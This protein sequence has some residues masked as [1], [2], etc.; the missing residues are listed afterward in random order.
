MPAAS[1]TA[2]SAAPIFRLLARIRRRAWASIWIDSLAVVILAAVAT[3]GLLLALDWLLEPPA[4]ARAIALA[5]VAGLLLWLVIVR[6]F[7][8]LATPLP[9]ASLALAVE[10]RHPDFGDTL[11]TAVELATG[12]T[13]TVD[14]DLAARTT[15]AAA[16]LARVTRP[17]DLFRGRRLAG[18]A[19]AGLAAVGGGVGMAARWPDLARI[20]VRRMVLLHDVAWP[21][22]V[23][24]EAEGFRDGVRKVPRGADV[25]VVVRARSTA[26]LPESVY[27]RSQGPDGWQSAR[28]GTRGG[29]EAGGQVFEHRLERVMADTPLEIRGGDGR[30]RGLRLEVVEPPAIEAV[31]AV[32]RL[33]AYLGGGERTPPAGRL[34]AA[35][36]GSRVE[37]TFKATKPLSAAS[38]TAHALAAAAADAVPEAVPPQEEAHVLA[39][40]EAADAGGASADRTEIEA[41]IPELVSDCRLTVVVTDRHGITNREPVTLLLAAVADERPQIDLELA[42]ISTAVTP[43][44]CLAITGSIRDDHGLATAAVKVVRRDDQWGLPITAVGGGESLVEFPPTDPLRV[45]LPPLG[46]AVGDR[47]AVSVSATDRCGLADGPNLGSSDT[48]TLEVVSPDALRAMLEAREI[49]LRRRYEAAIEDLVVA[50]QELALPPASDPAARA[51]RIGEAAARASGES[52]EIGLAFRDIRDELDH[53]ALLTAEVETRLVM[54]VAEPVA[55]IARTSLARLRESARD[56]TRTEALSA[57][58]DAAIEAMRGV[59]AR[60]LE[61][62]SYNEVIEKLRGV[63]ESQERIRAET[64]ERQ[65][66]RARE[67]LEGL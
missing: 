44:A 61:L 59:L 2:A 19:L 8:R 50:G 23:Q 32:V 40:F 49:L 58:T 17:G 53:N 64:L 18:I 33:P 54:Q 47:I 10:R 48:W 27:L 7:G 42:G 21:R 26:A 29:A 6:L 24:L 4:W 45:P 41:V 38:V 14:P 36:R 22:Q 3:A 55:T 12:M 62:E 63:I 60:M 1:P 5:G 25:E 65:R 34:V 20:G 51:G 30:L 57:E 9:D 46:L 37:L 31:T 52:E 15:A 28:M 39:A 16:A 67:A 43:Q 66:R 11:S 35:A 13:E 56:A